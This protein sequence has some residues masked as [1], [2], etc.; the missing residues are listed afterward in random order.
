[1][2]YLIHEN[3]NPGNWY[4]KGQIPHTQNSSLELQIGEK[5]FWK[6]HI[7][8]LTNKKKKLL[9][10]RYSKMGDHSL[11]LQKIDFFVCIPHLIV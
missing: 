8:L 2:L 3:A 4:K 10:V 1:M 5:L 7:Y 9:V 6:K 11:K